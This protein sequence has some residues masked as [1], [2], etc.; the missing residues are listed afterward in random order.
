MCSYAIGTI[1]QY[2]LLVIKARPETFF[3]HNV[4]FSFILVCKVNYLKNG[5]WCLLK[6]IIIFTFILIVAFI[7]FNMILASILDQ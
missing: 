1:I 7:A 6:F 5:G 2:E 4:L 3:T